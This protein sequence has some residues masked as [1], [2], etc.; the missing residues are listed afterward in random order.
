MGVAP[1]LNSNSTHQEEARFSGRLPSGG[2]G[3]TQSEVSGRS[4]ED[5]KES[6]SW[7]G[8]HLQ[9]PSAGSLRS[10]AAGSGKPSPS[11]PALEPHLQKELDLRVQ[12][13]L[14][15]VQQQ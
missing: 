14:Q 11:A 15:E 6:R 1:F 12:G 10:L 2:S 13:K 3:R 8:S 4:V 5:T 9:S 7:K